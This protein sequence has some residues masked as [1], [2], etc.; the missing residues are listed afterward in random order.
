M[1]EKM[2]RT[3]RLLCLALACAALLAAALLR[4]SRSGF[5]KAERAILD[6]PDPVLYVEVVDN[7]P[8]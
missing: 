8:D 4:G 1:N 2:K 6:V 7:H 5:T 3:L